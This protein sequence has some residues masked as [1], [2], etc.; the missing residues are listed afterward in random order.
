ICIEGPQF[1][2]RAESQSFRN[3]NFDIIG[4]TNLQEA[5]LAR[6][7]EICYV[8][9]ALVTDYDC[10]KENED[11]SIELVIEN[12]KKNSDNAK[13]LI[14]EI[15]KSLPKKRYCLCMTALKDAII[16]PKDKIPKKTLEN[17]SLIIN[18]YI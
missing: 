2:T 13:R 17:L 6:E 3:M 15:V 18:K 12:L 16:T 7:A 5:K 4:M 8:T 10:W 11:V 1:S 14:V 9:I